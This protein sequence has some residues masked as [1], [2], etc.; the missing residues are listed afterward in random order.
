M[1]WTLIDVSAIPGVEVGDEVTL[2]GSDNGNRISAE[3]WAEKVGSIS[4][5][6]FCSVGKRVPRRYKD[7]A[8]P[9]E[10]RTAESGD[11]DPEP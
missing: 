7:K 6:V 4:Y 5:E 8:S 11:S 9:A 10:K 1:D 3:E 2:L